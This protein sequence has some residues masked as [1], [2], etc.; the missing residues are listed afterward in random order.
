[1]KQT[2]QI[3]RKPKYYQLYCHI[4]DLIKQGKF[5]ENQVLPGDNEL[6]STFNLSRSSVRQA[7]GELVNAGMISRHKGAGSFVRN[8]SSWNI[9]GNNTQ[10]TF[11]IVAK[12]PISAKEN[13]FYAELLYGFLNAQ[14]SNNISIH[15]CCEDEFDLEFRKTYDVIVFWGGGPSKRYDEIAPKTPI[16]YLD[17]EG[18]DIPNSATV[19]SPNIVASEALV[20]SLLRQNHSPEKIGFV[21]FGQPNNSLLRLEGFKKALENCGGYCEDLIW[22]DMHAEC[23]I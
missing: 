15:I 18:P 3:K 16:V 4:K 6:M 14:M 12:Y 7:M 5:V 10:K 9:D 20:Q 8:K 13:S 1:M 11:L 22:I 2:V 17:Y 23:R 21:A 19:C